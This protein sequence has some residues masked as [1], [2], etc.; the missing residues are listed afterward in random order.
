VIFYDD[1]L[2]CFVIV[3]ALGPSDNSACVLVSEDSRGW[4]GSQY[5]VGL[6]FVGWL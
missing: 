6:E 1:V 3:E 4:V 2:C 5:L